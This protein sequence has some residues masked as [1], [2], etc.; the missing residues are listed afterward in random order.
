LGFGGNLTL[1]HLQRES[2]DLFESG[3]CGVVITQHRF[4]GLGSITQAANARNETELA[5]TGMKFTVYGKWSMVYGSK[6]GC[7]HSRRGAKSARLKG[8]FRAR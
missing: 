2:L 5:I 6:V 7:R 1:E 8:Y 4:R 3:L